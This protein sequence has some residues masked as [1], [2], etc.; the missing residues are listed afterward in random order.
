MSKL[1]DKK[2]RK[3]TLEEGINILHNS[4]LIL[5]IDNSQVIKIGNSS[6]YP[7]AYEF[8]ILPNKKEEFIP[9]MC[10]NLDTHK[11]IWHVIHSDSLKKDQIK[12][13]LEIHPEHINSYKGFFRGD[14][15]YY[16][17]ITEK[18]PKDITFIELTGKDYN[19]KTKFKISYLKK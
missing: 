7:G 1:S 8:H 17:Y 13:Q 5:S 6:K 9:Y 15:I 3:K 11:N 10:T 16:L 19:N 2:Q 18:L 4:N 14:A 12:F